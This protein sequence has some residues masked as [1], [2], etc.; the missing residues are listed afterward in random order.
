MLRKIRILGFGFNSQS[1]SEIEIKLDNE[2]IFQGP[3]HTIE[4]APGTIYPIVGVKD[5]EPSGPG[6]I[7]E[8]DQSL[9]ATSRQL[10]I[11]S[12]SGNF[13]F[14]HT[15][16]NYM[17][18]RELNN[19]TVS[20]SS[21]PNF[22][23]SCYELKESENAYYRDSNADVKIDG[24]P[25]LRVSMHE[26]ERLGQHYWSILQGQKFSSTMLISQGLEYPL[27]E[28]PEDEPINLDDFLIWQPHHIQSYDSFKS[29]I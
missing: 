2:L 19:P 11:V 27:Y 14:T 25:Q 18:L 8:W 15:Y 23:L 26:S 9:D 6:V 7:V 5:S 29:T 17:P 21:G 13:R 20:Y 12:L 3:V 24:R 28:F 22:W 1:P 16:S 10:E 4:V